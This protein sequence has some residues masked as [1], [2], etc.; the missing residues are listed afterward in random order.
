MIKPCVKL[1]KSPFAYYAYDTNLNEIISISKEMYDEIQSILISN[2]KNENDISNE[3]MQIR[4]KG[5]LQNRQV[6][7]IG[8]NLNDSNML[9]LERNLKM[10]TLQVTQNCNLRCEYCVYSENINL[11]QRSHSN[12][13]M[14]IELAKKCIDFFHEH[15]INTNAPSIGFYGGEPLL[16][17]DLIKEIIEYAN[18]KFK[19]KDLHFNITTNGLFLNLNRAKFLYD[20]RVDIVLSLDGPKTIQNKYRKF[21]NGKDGTFDIIKDNIANIK[22][23]IPDLYNRIGINSVINPEDDLDEID[24][25]KNDEIFGPLMIRYSIVDYS[26]DDELSKKKYPQ[27]FVFDFEYNMFCSRLFELGYIKNEDALNRITKENNNSLK[28]EIKKM[29]RN[30]IFETAIPSGQCL[31]GELRL[32]V[33]CTGNFYSCEKVCESSDSCIGNINEGFDFVKIKEIMNISK[34]TKE[35]CINCWAFQLCNNCIFGC[36]DQGL[37]SKQKR[38]EKCNRSKLAAFQRIKT[39]IQNYESVKYMHKTR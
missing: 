22:R 27:K 39:K 21:P 1:V 28:R 18:E 4:N 31:P 17:F 26:Y 7:D 9:K 32:F 2:G 35:N 10:L 24:L 16:E 29:K 12:K 33:D 11:G 8:F 36:F 23:E 5:Y 38:L 19:G 37:I 20:N 15:S 14:S 25:L 6:Q 13:K 30:P 34:E 3:L